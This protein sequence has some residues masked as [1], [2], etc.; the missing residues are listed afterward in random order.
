MV[1]NDKLGR[2]VRAPMLASI[3]LQVPGPDLPLGLTHP[4]TSNAQGQSHES[5]LVTAINTCMKLAPFM[6][7][8]S[9]HCC[10]A[11]GASSF[12]VVTSIHCHQV[13]AYT[14]TIQLPRPENA[15]SLLHLLSAT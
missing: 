11:M 15:L 8:Y 1:H 7:Q 2:L 3:V 9:D 10:Y 6:S 12:G 4:G 14:L 5:A 13:N